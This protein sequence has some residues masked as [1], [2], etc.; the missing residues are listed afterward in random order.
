MPVPALVSTLMSIKAVVFDWHGLLEDSFLVCPLHVPMFERTC[1]CL[2]E[3]VGASLGQPVAEV[4]VPFHGLERSA[5]QGCHRLG[6]SVL[7]S[8]KR[9]E[10]CLLVRMVPGI[11]GCGSTHLRKKG[12]ES[13]RTG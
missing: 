7:G 10:M 11:W 5:P 8:W 2:W 3:V 12:S 4:T 6:E 1:G 13:W 9:P